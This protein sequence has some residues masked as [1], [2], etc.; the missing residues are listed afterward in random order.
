[1]ALSCAGRLIALAVLVLP[2]LP[3]AVAAGLPYRAEVTTAC[4]AYTTLAALVLL[5]DR[6]RR[7]FYDRLS[8]TEVVMLRRED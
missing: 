3:P 8:G 7:A 1:M 5:L 2:L 6:R 4:A